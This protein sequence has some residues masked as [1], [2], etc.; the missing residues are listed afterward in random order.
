M[1]IKLKIFLVL[2]MSFLGGAVSAEAASTEKEFTVN[3]WATNLYYTESGILAGTR[4]SSFP[5][6]EF[7]IT[8]ESPTWSRLTDEELR[9]KLLHW[10]LKKSNY[11]YWGYSILY[12]DQTTEFFNE[13]V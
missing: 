2:L 11:T 4:R 10:I 6:E 9:D 1:K 7:M 5:P 13:T 12:Q 3:Q 8:K